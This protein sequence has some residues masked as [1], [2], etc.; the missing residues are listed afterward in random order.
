MR[1]DDDRICCYCTNETACTTF[2]VTALLIAIPTA[3]WGVV[4]CSQC[5]CFP[6]SAIA[7]YGHECYECCCPSFY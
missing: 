4:A 2:F 1:I 7:C 3:T 6:A 5:C